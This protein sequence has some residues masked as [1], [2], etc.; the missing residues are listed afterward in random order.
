M[1]AKYFIERFCRDVNKATMALSPAAA[2]ELSAYPWPGNVRELQNCIERA[3]IL[4]EGDTI[5]PRHLHLSFREAPA[6][7]PSDADDG[8]WS[9]INLSGTLAEASRRVIAEVER[10]KIDQA[11]TE[12]AGNR[13][14]AAEILQVSF[15][16]FLGKLKEYGFES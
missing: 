15:K 16:S 1:L 10:R 5:H 3:V 2:E 4:T 6:A 9:K 7:A 14:R 13:G 11:L 12:A 8:P